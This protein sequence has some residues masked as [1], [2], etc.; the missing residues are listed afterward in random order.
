MKIQLNSGEGGVTINWLKEIE[1]E[2]SYK[3]YLFISLNALKRV[4][5]F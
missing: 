3:M 5:F 2:I 4:K 1:R